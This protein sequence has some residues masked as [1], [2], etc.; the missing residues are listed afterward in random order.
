MRTWMLALVLGCGSSTEPPE[1]G[2][3]SVAV[4]CTAATAATIDD[5][6]EVRGVVAP[7]PNLDATISSPIAGRVARVFV[8]EG[9]AVTA[10]QILATVEEPSLPSGTIEARAAEDS[11]R[12]DKVA[13]DL[14]LARQEKLVEAGLVARRELER[15]RAAA[16][17][18]TASVG[19]ARARVGAARAN[20]ARRE[21][22]APYA[23]VV[24]HLW[25]RTGEFVDGT[26]TSTPVAEVANISTLEVRAQVAPSVLAPVRDGMPASVTLASQILPA[27]VVR[28]APA[29]DPTTLL[30]AVR[31]A[32]DGTHAI[33]VGIA[34]TARISIG[35]HSGVLVPA[36]A[37][38][39]SIVGADELVVCDKG[40]ARVRPVAIAQRSERGVEIASGLAAGEQVVTDHVLGL[41]DGQPVTVTG[42]P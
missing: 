15:A 30:G 34:A 21:L 32:I 25:K 17:V 5:I 1:E 9:D 6:V 33:P 14:E 26:A 3:P 12:A 28:V 27:H 41:E 7:P 18:A 11:A 37:I 40:T 23:G 29:V 38:R 39:R 36:A 19:A 35:T 22:R 16:A 4:T 31:I 8:E 20:D 2:T 10:G 13:A 24:L 42:K